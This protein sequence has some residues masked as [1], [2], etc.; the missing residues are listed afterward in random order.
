ME[1]TLRHTIF[2]SIVAVMLQILIV[3]H[4]SQPGILDLKTPEMK[5][6]TTTNSTNFSPSGDSGLVISGEPAFVGDTLTASL[7]VTNKGNHTG[8]V[9]L[10]I[11]HY[12][13]ERLFQGEYISIS[14]G[15]TRE[16]QT[17]FTTELPGKNEF[18]WQLE[19]LGQHGDANLEGNLSIEASSSQILSLTTKSISWSSSGGLE[20]EIS[21]FLSEGKTRPILLTVSSEVSEGTKNLQ[22]ILIDANPG[23]RVIDFSLGDPGSTEIT[24]QAIPIQWKSSNVSQNITKESIVAPYIDS[25]SVILDAFFIPEKPSPGSRVLVDVSISNEDEKMAQTGILRLISSSERTILAESPV[26]SLTPGSSVNIEMS[27]PEWIERDN[28]DVEVQWSSDG[29]VS[30]RIYSI[31][32]NVDDRGLELP[33]DILAAGYGILAGTLIILVGTFSWRAVSSRTPTT[34]DFRLREAKESQSS[35]LNIEKREIKCS[36]CDQ[37]LTV[38]NDHMGAV[39]CPSCTMEFIVGGPDESNEGADKLSVVKSTED[40][41]HCPT[42][43]QALRVQLEK[44]PVMSRCPVCKTQFMAETEGEQDV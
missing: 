27:I 11:T 41:L 19:V 7:M 34:S 30:S 24:I 17:R 5:S 16:V 42:C 29:V 15:S 10:Q 13:S 35:Q 6:S 22:G 4:A 9:S 25:S 32:P 23:R 44:R 8:S 31:E 33:F 43:D 28:V 2:I 14:P 12:E 38:P 1:V 20:I 18:K 39:R 3:H 36:F 37:R 26:P 40:I 21:V